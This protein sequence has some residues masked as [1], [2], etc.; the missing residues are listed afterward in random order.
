MHCFTCVCKKSSRRF[1]KALSHLTIYYTSF[2]SIVYR[3][4]SLSFPEMIAARLALFLGLFVAVTHALGGPESIPSVKDL[5]PRAK[6]LSHRER[7]SGKDTKSANH[8]LEVRNILLC[9]VTPQIFFKYLI[10]PLNVT[11][12]KS[13]SRRTPMS[14]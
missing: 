3:N 9:S 12:S 5:K 4:P 7:K 8:G 10:T 13:S 11:H 6:H 1:F 2:E 14:L